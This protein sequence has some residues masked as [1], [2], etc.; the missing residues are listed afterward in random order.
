MGKTLAEKILSAKSNTDAK[1]GDIV[2]V[3]VDVLALQDGTGPL[4]IQQFDDMG[5]ESVANPDKT[6]FFMDHAAPSPRKE[7]SNAH[8]MIR[9]FADRTGAKYSEICEGVIHQRLVESVTS[10]GDVVIGADS[11]TCMSGALGAFATGMGSTDLAVAMAAGKTWMKVPET[12]KVELRGEFPS[13]VSPKDAIIY[14]IG[15]IGADGATYQALEFTGPTVE[16]MEMTD[17]FTLSNMAVES[18]AKAGLIAADEISKKYLTEQGRPDD[19]RPV[20]AD[21][22]GEYLETHIIDVDKLVP[23]ISSPHTVDNTGTVEDAAG[24]KVEQ[25]FIGSCTNGRLS[26]LLEAAKILKGRT[27]KKGTRLIVT[28]ASREVYLEAIKAGVVEELVKA[29]AMITG[30]GCG[31][32]VGVHGGI[33]GDGEVCVATTNRN[34]QG[35]MGNPK[36]SIYLASP[37]TAAATAVKGEIADPREFIDK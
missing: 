15:K 21:V 10:P 35:R 29:G 24:K 14:F 32:C 9:S 3:D 6:I 5:A 37:A 20:S 28:P 31:A 26:D 34:F 2:I 22:D 19:Y 25:V 4:A 23:M 16:S 18:G 13:G 33:L 7:L 8:M 36:G 17:R 1:A 11:H 30:P 27:V 12:I